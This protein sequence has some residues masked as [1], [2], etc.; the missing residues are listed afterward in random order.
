MKTKSRF[1]QLARGAQTKLL[2]LSILTALAAGST[3]QSASLSELLE[4]GIYSEQTRGDLDSALQAYQ[5][6]V[7]ESKVGEALAAQAQYR[8]GVVQYK[9]KNYPEATAAF[10]LLVKNYP[11]QK[12]LVKLA[13]EYLANAALL[14][15]APWVDGED[16]RLNVKL[17]SGVKIGTA[18]YTVDAAELNGRKIWRI[19]SYLYAGIKQL[20]QVEVEAESFKP[21]HCRW[22]HT[23]IG[24][25][26]TTYTPGK[27]EVKL[28]GQDS[29]KSTDIEGVLYDNEEALALMRRLPLA[30]NYSTSLRIFAGLAG[31]S[32]I[33]LKL[34][35]TAVETVKTPAGTFECYKVELSI[36]QT[37]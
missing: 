24:D 9:K 6:V 3:A 10:E 21:I 34:D 17:A 13:H 1:H 37:F 14:L 29:T 32:I 11:D 8:L 12:E 18:R 5:R 31:G 15:P 35:V 30:T 19:S 36:K 23:L 2:L 7:S 20:S 28:L 27:A 26:E 22:K 33:P 16:L 4:Q 25:S